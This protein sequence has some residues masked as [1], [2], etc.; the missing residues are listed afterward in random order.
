MG[1]LEPGPRKGV[2]ELVRVFMEAPGDFFVGRIKAQR[3]V[4][5]QHHRLVLLAL[6]LGIGHLWVGTFS[7]PL[8]GPGRA[9]GE[10]PLEAEQMVEKGIDLQLNT[11]IAEME[12]RD[13]GVWTKSVVGHEAVFDQVLFATGRKPNTDGLG[14]EEAGAALGRGGEIV[15]DEYSQT[16]VPSIYA[17]G[18]V[19][20]R[21]N[22]TPVA[23]RAG[24]ALVQTVLVGNPT[25]VDYDLIPSATFTQPEMGTA[26]LSVVDARAP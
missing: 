9:F 8:L 12:K 15:V 6:V 22:L 11:D 3:Q 16:G 14:I 7:H 18:D 21:V 20:N 23:I 19:T 25:P 10:F 26:G 5:G 2:G 24:M 13:G 4:R 1:Q 17:I